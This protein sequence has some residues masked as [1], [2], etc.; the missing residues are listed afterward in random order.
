MHVYGNDSRED[1]EKIKHREKNKDAGQ[2]PFEMVDNIA[3]TVKKLENIVIDYCSDS[4]KS[5]E[6]SE[7]KKIRLDCLKQKRQEIKEKIA[8]NNMYED[9]K[10]GLAVNVI[11]NS[12][13]TTNI[14]NFNNELWHACATKEV[15]SESDKKSHDEN[16]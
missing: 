16:D 8:K 3:H 10:R 9:R 14:K 6:L 5:E 11:E 4:D 13:E 2:R 7:R 12:A 1:D 15:D